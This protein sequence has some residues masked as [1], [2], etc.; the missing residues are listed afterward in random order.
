MSIYCMFIVMSHEH[1]SN[2]KILMYVVFAVAQFIVIAIASQLLAITVIR[3]TRGMHSQAF[4]KVLHSPLSFF[5]TTTMRRILNRFSKD[6]DAL[7]NILW[8]TLN[9][10]FYTLLTVLASVTLT[11]VYFPWLI[12]AILP[13]AGGYYF[14][15]PYYRATSRETKRLDT[16]LHSHLLAHFSEVLTG[17]GTQSLRTRQAHYFGQPGQTRFEQSAL[18]SLPR[19]QSLDRVPSQRFWLLFGAHEGM[20]MVGTRFTIS[21]ASAGL[22]LSYLTRTSGDMNWVVQCIATLVR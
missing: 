11:L 16:T 19:R 15:S 1:L 21:A 7:D 10:I 3:T 18:L 13:M 12:V 2:F 22:F 8:M 14:L 4:D 5:D 6:V 9:D 20:F 17:M